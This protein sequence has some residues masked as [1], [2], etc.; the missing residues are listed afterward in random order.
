M[1]DDTLLA[2]DMQEQIWAMQEVVRKVCCPALRKL[3]F[4]R[5]TLNPSFVPVSAPGCL[6]M[7]PCLS[8]AGI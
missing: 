8:T 2:E 7:T 6:R 5:T 1:R 3:P 4:T